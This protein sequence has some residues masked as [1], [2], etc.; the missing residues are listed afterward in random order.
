[1]KLPA[2]G[3]IPVVWE[4]NAPV[5]EL[6]FGGCSRLQVARHKLNQRFLASLVDACICNT[7][8]VAEYACT[9]LGSRKNHVVPLG[10]DPDLF[11]P[12]RADPE[13]YAGCAGSFKV[14]WIG[15][16]QNAWNGVKRILEIPA[17]L[18]AVD[19][20]ITMIMIGH[21]GILRR[22]AKDT[23]RCFF[24][25]EISYF[26]TP[27]YLASADVGLCVYMNKES[28]TSHYRSPLKLFDYMASGLPVVASNS[29]QIR[30]V[31]EGC[32]CGIVVNNTKQEIA[33]AILHLK[34]NPEERV[35]MGRNARKGVEDFYNWERVAS[36][37]GELLE[38]LIARK[39]VG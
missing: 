30:E 22:Y 20:D 15:T 28:D 31:V 16:P 39:G 18:A 17:Q 37:T 3:K 23:V 12:S 13:L 7:S 32:Q 19:P 6:R 29:G 38:S 4:L 5:D 36:Q 1:M 33:D 14:A 27:P 9:A 2:L 24:P 8:A 21:E 35:R 25:G 34:R 10:S 26:D 11:S